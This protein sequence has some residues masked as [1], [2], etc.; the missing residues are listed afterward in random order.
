MKLFFQHTILPANY[1]LQS[2]VLDGIGETDLKTI[3]FYCCLNENGKPAQTRV[4][5]LLCFVFW[6]PCVNVSLAC[7]PTVQEVV[8]V[9]ALF[10][11]SICTQLRLLFKIIIFIGQFS[12]S[13]R[14]E[15]MVVFYCQHWKNME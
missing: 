14:D 13:I 7:N 10:S 1:Q 8:R 4:P 12:H 15:N 3:E 11:K 5:V 9:Y 6:Q 2:G